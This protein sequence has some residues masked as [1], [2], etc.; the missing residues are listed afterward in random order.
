VAAASR[1]R[2][3]TSSEAWSDGM[4]RVS[5]RECRRCWLW[6]VSCRVPGCIGAR[7][8]I[9]HG[10]T[11]GDDA[12]RSGVV[13][14]NLFISCRGH[15]SHGRCGQSSGERASA[16][17]THERHR[18]RQGNKQQPATTTTSRSDTRARYF[19][20]ERRISPSPGYATLSCSARSRH[21]AAWCDTVEL[22]A[23]D[24]VD[25]ENVVAVANPQ[26]REIEIDRE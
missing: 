4:S 25:G 23:S 7:R 10:D 6:L 8:R 15:T 5:A 13:S 20:K 19:A 11:A 9:R 16:R 12:D 1:A 3:R 17:D 26:G 24:T 18:H 21:G 2:R 22:V 14:V